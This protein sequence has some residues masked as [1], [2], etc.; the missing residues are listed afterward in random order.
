MALITYFYIELGE[1]VEFFGKLVALDITQLLSRV[2]IG[3]FVDLLIEAIRNL[4]DAFLWFQYWGD[5]F[6]IRNG[7]YW[8]I[9]AYLGYTL[10]AQLAQRDPFTLRFRDV[11]KIKTYR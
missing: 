1:L 6:D 10:G 2:S 7:W 9:A 11:F 4:I 3:L 5:E 8:L